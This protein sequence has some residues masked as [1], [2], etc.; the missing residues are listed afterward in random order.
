MKIIGDVNLYFFHDVTSPT[1]LSSYFEN[2]EE[3]II[4]GEI[5][6]FAYNPEQFKHFVENKLPSLPKLKFIKSKNYNYMNPTFQ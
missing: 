2:L 6:E 5:I 4:E 1:M 3:L